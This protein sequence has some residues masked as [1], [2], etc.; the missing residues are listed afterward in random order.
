M[1]SGR[2]SHRGGC[3][4]RVVAD[5]PDPPVWRGFTVEHFS[6]CRGRQTS[7]PV[8]WSCPRVTDL[9]VVPGHERKREITGE[10]HRAVHDATVMM[11][12]QRAV[13]AIAER[14][15]VVKKPPEVQRL[16]ALAWWN[17]LH[18]TRTPE[19]D[20]KFGIQACSCVRRLIGIGD[21]HEIVW[22]WPISGRR[23]DQMPRSVGCNQ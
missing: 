2:P 5:V 22:G 8:R 14:S 4:V 1:H 3:A 12:D 16:L 21:E 7:A 18:Q 6:N 9:Q 11:N 13:L 20:A 17:Q 10:D 19:L 23:Q 15:A